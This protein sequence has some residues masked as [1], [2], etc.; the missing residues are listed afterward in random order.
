MQGQINTDLNQTG[1]DQAA[2]AGKRLKNET[3]D[4]VSGQYQVLSIVVFCLFKVIISLTPHDFIGNKVNFS[5]L[6]IRLDQGLP[7]LL[8]N[9][10]PQ[11]NFSQRP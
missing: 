11:R 9:F 2:K 3:F 8:H 4:K 7:D 5:G 10:V 1:K 6:F